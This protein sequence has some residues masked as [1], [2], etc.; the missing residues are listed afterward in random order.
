MVPVYKCPG[1]S[2]GKEVVRK[3]DARARANVNVNTLVTCAEAR[4]EHVV[5]K[6]V[7]NEKHEIINRRS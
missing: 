6:L 7:Y 2:P 5:L 3:Y 1:L 4:I